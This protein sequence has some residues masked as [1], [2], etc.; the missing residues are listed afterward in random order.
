MRVETPKKRDQK[1]RREMTVAIKIVLIIC[2][3]DLY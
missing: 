3:I 1:I 2:S